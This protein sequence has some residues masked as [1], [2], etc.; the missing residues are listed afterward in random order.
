MGCVRKSS[1]EL[2]SS[3]V[4]LRYWF[5][6]YGLCHVQYYRNHSMPVRLLD[7]LSSSD[8]DQKWVDF[9]IDKSRYINNTP[10]TCGDAYEEQ[11]FVLDTAC[12]II[13]TIEYLL[14]LY[15]APDRC[16]FLRYS[17]ISREK[18]RFN[19]QDFRSIMSIIDVVAILP[20]YIGLGLQNNKDVSG[21]FVTLRVF[22]SLLNSFWNSRNVFN[23]ASLPYFQVLPPLARTSNIGLHAKGEEGLVGFEFLN[24]KV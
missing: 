18:K 3:S 24:K 2:Y 10:V 16:K 7:K 14:R 19:F 22:V 1:H 8:F 13:F 5:L 9:I 23:L 15:A 17:K 6:H 20:Y 12:V 4:L 11:F 21:A